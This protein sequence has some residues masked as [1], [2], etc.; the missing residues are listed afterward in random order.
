MEGL[1]GG[2]R[3]SAACPESRLGPSVCGEALLLMLIN[4]LITNCIVFSMESFS[5]DALG[6]TIWKEVGW[7]PASLQAVPNC[8]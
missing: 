5:I 1:K 3:F 7:P 8:A 2:H 6:S 4:D